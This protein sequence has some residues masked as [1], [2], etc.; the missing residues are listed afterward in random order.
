MRRA[1]AAAAV[2]LWI[3]CWGG[4]AQ[5]AAQQR[6]ALLVSGASGGEEYATRFAAWIDAFGRT[7][8]ER[9]RFEARNVTVLSDVEAT[10]QTATA[11]NVRRAI[12]AV[13]QRM[14]RDDLLFVLLVGHGTFDGTEAKYNLVGPDLE[15]SEWAALLQTLPGRVVLVNGTSGS[16]PFI[17]R[18]AGPR[19]IVIT[20][21]DSEAQRFD[22]VF[23]EY[24]VKAFEDDAADLDKNQRIS[25]WEA[26][27]YASAGVRRHYQQRGLL[28]TERSLLDD[29]GDGAGKGAA[30]RGDDGA[31]A[32]RTYLDEELPGAAPTDEELLKLLQRKALVEAELEELKI[33]KAFLPAGEYAK[34]FERIIIDLARVSRDI[35][36]RLKT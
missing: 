15:A 3:A 27:A 35:R 21:T 17:E 24:F 11:A 26:F 34:E 13:R 6:F 2:L 4:S 28:P 22:T 32:S 7:L 31:H 29:N 36:Q 14:R 18:L 23:P 33:R 20:A 8:T 16:F 10:E 12:A 19:R 9:L 30:E 5:V 1:L 25:I